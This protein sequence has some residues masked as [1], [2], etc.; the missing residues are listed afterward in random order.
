[1]RAV[2]RLVRVAVWCAVP[3]V[4]L[5]AVLLSPFALTAVTGGGIDWERA[6][7]IGQTYGA[8]SA[9]LSAIALIGV[10]ASIV[11]QARATNQ[12]RTQAVRQMHTDLIRMAL[13]DPAYLPCWGMGPR[14]VGLDERQAGYINLILSHWQARWDLGLLDARILRVLVDDLFRAEAPRLYWAEFGATRVDTTHRARRSMLQIV[15]EQYRKAVTAG[16]PERPAAVAAPDATVPA[17]RYDTGAV[18]V[19]GG[20]VALGAIAV[21]IGLRR[22]P[23]GRPAR[24]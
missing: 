23:A 14:T 17:R 5:A 24:R 16:P 6:S 11:L 19:A 10:G 2:P 3:L 12:A 20:L 13:D 8:A 9:I 15:D 18:V 4:M 21:G 1:M 22:R 7:A